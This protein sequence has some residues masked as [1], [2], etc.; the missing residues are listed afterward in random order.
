[1]NNS[2]TIKTNIKQ[3]YN[4]LEVPLEEYDNV[5]CVEFINITDEY[6]IEF[7]CKFNNITKIIFFKDFN[8]IILKNSKIANLKKIVELYQVS[9]IDGDLIYFSSCISPILPNFIYENNMLIINPNEIIIPT[10]IKFLNII[11]RYDKFN[12]LPNSLEH[13][14]IK[15]FDNINLTNL[16]PTLQILELVIDKYELKNILKN[17][18]LPYNCE[19]IWTLI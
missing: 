1:M 15:I 8:N 14:K 12:N 16:P 5:L 7:I 17:I 2:V 9:N 11:C 4:L 18:K 13:L 10:N 19:L 6:V 3:Y